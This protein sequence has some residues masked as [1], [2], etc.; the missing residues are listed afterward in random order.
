MSRHTSTAYSL[1][2]PLAITLLLPL[3]A[4]MA[5]AATTESNPSPVFTTPGRVIEINHH[6]PVSAEPAFDR[7]VPD[8]MLV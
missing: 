6:V 7:I 5:W 2:R 1:V 8:T 4:A 3:G